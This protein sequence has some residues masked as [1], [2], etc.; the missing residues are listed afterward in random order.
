MS[1]LDHVRLPDGRRLEMRVSGPAGGLPLVFNHGTPGSGAAPIR[2]WE[3]AAHARGLRLV[4]MSRPGYGGSDRRPGRS[5]V[6]VVAD[7][8]AVVEAIGS[9]RCLVAG[10]SGGGPHA[11][12][13]AARLDAA[14]AVLALAGFAPYD[15]DGLDWFAGM[16]EENVTEFSAAARGEDELRAAAA[17]WSDYA[18]DLTGAQMA[19]DLQPVLAEGE[20]AVLSDEFVEDQA[21]AI[22][23]GFRTGAEGYI[24]DE[25]AFIRPWGFDL[26]EISAPTMIWQGTA[27]LLVPCSHG[28][29]LMP[30]VPGALAHLEDGDGHFSLALRPLDRMLDELVNATRHEG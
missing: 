1:G 23:E 10:W 8:A 24:D 9:E 25:L 12:A 29:W 20:Q 30:R 18:K 15:A 22:Q 3:R 13:C 28:Q 16:T 17:E 27:D 4:T 5:V 6:D 21:I 19:T 14:E 7:T 2:A 11:L 26:A